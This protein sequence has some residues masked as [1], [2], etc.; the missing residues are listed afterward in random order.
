MAL[1]LAEA[2]KLSNDTLLRGVIETTLTESDILNYLPFVEIVGNGLTYNRVN[3][4][5]TAGF[6][7]VGDTWVEQT[8]DF[9]QLTASLAI[10]GGD[11]DVDNFIRQTRQNIQ[12]TEAAIV[13]LKAK[14]V[15]HKYDDTFING[16]VV[17]DAK[18]FNGLGKLVVAGQTVS[19][20]VNGAALTLDML[21]E[22]IDLVKPGKPDVLIM[23]KKMRRKLKSLRRAQASSVIETELNGFGRMISFYDGIPVLIDD[24][25]SN[26]QTQGNTSTNST[27]YGAQL[28]EDGVCGLT[29]GGITVEPIGSLET[30]DATR[31]RIK[32]YSSLA[33]FNT[34]KLAALIGCQ[35]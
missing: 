17:V 35:G 4:V 23:S 24:Y 31:T 8:P 34:L 18:S 25:I 22:L 5:A 26:T 13:Q 16:D 1:T 33:L 7:S 15:S 28:G 14:A 11:A 32:W 20:G 3:T 12:D 19:M 9:T 2:A 21:D 27:I 29:N 30:K 10:L 6:Y